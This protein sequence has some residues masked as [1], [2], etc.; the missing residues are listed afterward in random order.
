MIH[1]KDRTAPYRN[2]N[3]FIFIGQSGAGKDWCLNKVR[4]ELGHP[5]LVSH[6]TRPPRP[7]E[8]DGVDYHFAATFDPE[9]DEWVEYREY[10]TIEDGEETTWFYW[11]APSELKEKERYVGILDFEG[12]KQL[13]EWSYENLGRRPTLVYVWASPQTLRHRAEARDGFEEEEFNRRLAADLEWEESA[14]RVADIIIYNDTEENINGFK[15][16]EVE[17]G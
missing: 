6:T 16:E 9:V 1:I 12:S 10:K 11:L 7:Q 2:M 5:K 8:V 17:R 3:Q 15:R 14:M 4:E 13:T